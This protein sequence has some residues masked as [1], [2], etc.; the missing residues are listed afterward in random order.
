MF[1]QFGEMSSS[2]EINELASNLLKENDIDSL[3]AM[4]QENGI[5]TEFVQF[6]INGEIEEL[7]DPLTAAVSK[8]DLECK[9][10]KVKEILADWVNYIKVQ[11]EENEEMAKAVR[12]K[13]KTLKGCIAELLKWSFKNQIPVSQEIIK[14]A[15]VNA[16]KVTLGIPGMGQAKKIIKQYYLG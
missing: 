9:E 13:G 1:E 12:K 7:C 6:F 5:A 14:A 3:K 8:L 11:A 2:K 15:G 16:G 10:L 4:A